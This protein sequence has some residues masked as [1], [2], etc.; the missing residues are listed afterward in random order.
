MKKSHLSDAGFNWAS[1]DNKDLIRPSQ[2]SSNSLNPENLENL[3]PNRQT[4]NLMGTN[5]GYNSEP[6]GEGSTIRSTVVSGVN[7]VTSRSKLTSVASTSAPV[8][9]FGGKISGSS[10]GSGLQG[11]M[12]EEQLRKVINKIEISTPPFS[13]QLL[14]FLIISA[15]VSE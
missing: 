13:D 2:Q 4:L 8:G 10:V 3:N 6:R 1:N 7:R 14:H 5:A 9:S 15:E 11:K 12:S